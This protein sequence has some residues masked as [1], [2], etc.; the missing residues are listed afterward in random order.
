MQEGLEEPAT[1]SDRISHSASTETTQALH[2]LQ[3]PPGFSRVQKVRNSFARSSS[4]SPPMDS[5]LARSRTPEPHPI[6]RSPSPGIVNGASI[7]GSKSLTVLPSEMNEVAELA[8]SFT[9]LSLPSNQR[10]KDDGLLHSQLQMRMSNGEEHNQQQ[11]QFIDKSGAKRLG[12]ATDYVGRVSDKKMVSALHNS[13][14]DF[15]GKMN[16]FRRRSLANVQ[17]P[18]TPPSAAEI[19]S[20][21]NS[22]ALLQV[23]NFPSGDGNRGYSYGQKLNMATNNKLDIG[24]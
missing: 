4:P 22:N 16:L 3:A 15:E 1:L 21:D 8:A 12:S 11:Q 19:T 20:L 14:L 10:L 24:N 18:P 13:N 7:A 23:D 2:T 17:S 9:G 6:A 5:S